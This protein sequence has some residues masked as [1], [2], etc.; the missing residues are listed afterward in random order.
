MTRSG[1]ASA[2]RVAKAAA[3][4]VLKSLHAFSQSG[5]ALLLTCAAIMLG[6]GALHANREFFVRHAIAYEDREQFDVTRVQ[7]NIGRLAVKVISV[8]PEPAADDPEVRDAQNR[9]W[10]R[11]VT[12][13]SF[14]A[15]VWIANKTVW[16]SWMTGG[17]RHYIWPLAWAVYL[18]G[19]VD[20]YSGWRV[21]WWLWDGLAY[22]TG[23]PGGRAV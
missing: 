20:M 12:S 3:L 6:T 13:L 14:W 16:A 5:L 10:H 1:T 9:A 7:D 18:V 8:K 2:A 15:F 19:M 4:S 17:A 23:G 21:T 11:H 22:L